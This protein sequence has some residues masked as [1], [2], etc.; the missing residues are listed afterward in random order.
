MLGNDR[1]D[2]VISD[3]IEIIIAAKEENSLE[4]GNNVDVERDDIARYVHKQAKLS[5]AAGALYYVPRH[6]GGSQGISQC[7][8]IPTTAHISAYQK[9]LGQLCPSF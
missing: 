7:R 1:D 3:Q 6:Y 5:Q 2:A 8:S 4:D 9:K